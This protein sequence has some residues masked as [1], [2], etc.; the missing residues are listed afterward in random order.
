[1][2]LQKGVQCV[3]LAVVAGGE[4]DS[5]LLFARINRIDKKVVMANFPC[6]CKPLISGTPE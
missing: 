5:D 1:M 4:K 2:N 3:T 6:L